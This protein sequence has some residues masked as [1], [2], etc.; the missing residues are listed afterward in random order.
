M[1][2]VFTAAV[3]DLL[4]R[5]HLN[6]LY[7]M[8]ARGDLTLVILHDEK[9]TYLN[10]NRFP[11]ES[12]ERRASNLIDTGLVDIVMFTRSRAPTLEFEQVIRKYRDWDLVFMRGDDWKDFPAHEVIARHGIPV[13]FVEYTE[14]V[15]STEIR[16]E[17]SA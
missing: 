1:T 12:L 17:I 14:G 13:E 7:K 9:S 6:L 3:C 15:S 8:R 5:G 10:K 4:H 16:S 11:V 2:L